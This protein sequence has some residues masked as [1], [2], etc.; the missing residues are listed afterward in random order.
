M[1]LSSSVGAEELLHLSAISQAEWSGKTL[2]ARRRL[3]SN[4]LPGH[5]AEKRV[6]DETEEA[7][8]QIL[9]CPI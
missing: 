7:E 5:F 6:R 2:P 3:Q 9:F 4:A 1:K 8:C